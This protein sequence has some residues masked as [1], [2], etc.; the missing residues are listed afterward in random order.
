MCSMRYDRHELRPPLGCLLRERGVEGARRAAHV[1]PV[2]AERTDCSRG[3]GEFRSGVEKGI[4]MRF[5]I[6]ALALGGILALGGWTQ[7]LGA[8]PG[9]TFEVV[10]IK[11]NTSVELGSRVAVLPSGRFIMTNM[12]LSAILFTAY[13]LQD[14]FQVDGLPEWAQKERFDIEAQAPA[15]VR[16]AFPGQGTALPRM[17]QA[18]LADRMKL[19][20]HVEKRI[21]PM[22]ELV[23][24]RADGRLGPN[25][26]PSS[27]DCTTAPT[28]P[29]AA[30]G[31]TPPPSAGDGPTCGN[32]ATLTS[33]SGM[34]I[35]LDRV[36]RLIIAPRVRRLVV[37]RTGLTGTFDISLRF[38]GP[39]PPPGAAAAGLP[40]SASDPDLAPIETA[41]QE[42]L[43]LKLQPIRE[44]ADVLVI[45]HIERP[46]AN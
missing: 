2:I 33:F 41:I 32:R 19:A 13:E 28:G 30:P 24:A 40:V 16:I 31:E 44:P 4:Q 7:H 38:R 26:S 15:G 39:E 22:F 35:P 6:T 23:L 10:S 17:L 3:A 18:M 34:G 21:V 36:I 45:D 11:P 8:Q 27:I 25:L 29:P 5:S 43:G 14:A 12:P 1:D 37:D 46:T 42:Q 20:T 9:L